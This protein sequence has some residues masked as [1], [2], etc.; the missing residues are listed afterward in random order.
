MI[1]CR[2]KDIDLKV[3]DIRLLRHE[4]EFYGISPLVKRLLLIEEMDHSGCGDLLFYCL[5]AAPSKI[6][7]CLIKPVLQ[8]RL[9]FDSFDSF[10]SFRRHSNSRIRSSSAQSR[11]VK[12]S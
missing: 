7:I 2:T 1:H 12:R 4:A 9:S 8:L 10:D 3:C 6:V 5:L 11:A